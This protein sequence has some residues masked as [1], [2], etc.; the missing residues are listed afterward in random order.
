MNARYQTLAALKGSALKCLI[1]FCW[2]R[3]QLTVTQLSA[4]VGHDDQ[5]V[6][7]ALLQLQLYGLA[8]PVISSQETWHLT[9]KGYQ[10]PLPFEELGPGD[11]SPGGERNSLSRT[12]TTTLLD[13]S[14]S[15]STPRGENFSSAQP[16]LDSP[17]DAAVSANLVAL[18]K[19]GIMGKKAVSLARLEWITPEYI[20]GSHARWVGEGYTQKDTGLLIRYMEDGDP[21]PIKCEECGAWGGHHAECRSFGDLDKLA[22]LVALGEVNSIKKPS[23]ALV[24]AMM[25]YNKNVHAIDY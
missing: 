12:T 17:I 14:S 5:T 21:C 16:P 4:Y 19:I 11:A 23:P 22:E 1:V 8:A 2:E 24:Q 18:H 13:P 20:E 9:D 10:L 6:R 7:S 15:S 3:K 25:R